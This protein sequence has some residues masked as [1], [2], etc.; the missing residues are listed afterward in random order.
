MYHS[1]I[2][3]LSSVRLL[4]LSPRRVPDVFQS[5]SAPSEQAGEVFEHPEEAAVRDVIF[6][7][8]HRLVPPDARPE[9]HLRGLSGPVVEGPEPRS[10]L[11]EDVRHEV[12]AD[13]GRGQD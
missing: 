13:T 8:P 7:L 1:P 9:L 5:S 11:A 10:H 2:A 6:Q 4:K 3:T 12:A